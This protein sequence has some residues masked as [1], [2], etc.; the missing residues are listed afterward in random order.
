M[1]AGKIEKKGFVVEVQ[2]HQQALKSANPITDLE[3][4][5]SRGMSDPYTDPKFVMN[6]INEEFFG[7]A[8]KNNLNAGTP[9]VENN[10]HNRE[11]MAFRSLPFNTQGTLGVNSLSDG[12]MQSNAMTQHALKDNNAAVEEPVQEI[13]QALSHLMRFRNA[14]KKHH[15]EL[16]SIMSP[17]NIP[18]LST[19]PRL[20]SNVK[21]AHVAS[22][23]IHPSPEK[24]ESSESRGL[25]ANVEIEQDTEGNDQIDAPPQGSAA[26]TEKTNDAPINVGDGS[27]NIG[28][29][30]SSLISQNG[31][32]SSD[33]LP[34]NPGA[35]TSKEM[36]DNFS[37]IKAFIDA[38]DDLRQKKVIE[39]IRNP[40]EDLLH[41][42]HK[43]H[44]VPKVKK[45]LKSIITS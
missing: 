43:K 29:A 24:Q 27:A 5:I 15:N 33:I 9:L 30:L 18:K 31:P 25:S 11:L 7:N 36:E 44:R 21:I 8:L 39:P 2:S 19:D 37:S 4:T 38:D 32:K 26:S 3:Q 41:S 17:F 12:L 10:L 13:N 22:E 6:Q 34:S 45:T 23:S 16:P 35:I 20:P 28:D 42:K 1:F 40:L 14:A